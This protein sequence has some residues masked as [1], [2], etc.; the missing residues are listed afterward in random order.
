ML[1]RTS[2]WLKGAAAIGTFLLAGSVQAQEPASKATLAIRAFEA[3]PAVETAARAAGTGNALE[4]I[5]QGAEGQME[6]A[7]QQTRKFQIVARGDL[8]TILKEQDLADS[9]L[10]N[11]LR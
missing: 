3:T 7:V 6:N 8:K 5:L 10:V 9:G 11:R 4:Q 2:G 1:I